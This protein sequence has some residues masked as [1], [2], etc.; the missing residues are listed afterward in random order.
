MTLVVASTIDG[1]NFVYSNPVTTNFNTG[2]AIEKVSGG[3]QLSNSSGISTD[4]LYN[5]CLLCFST[6][7]TADVTSMVKNYNQTNSILV[8]YFFQFPLVDTQAHADLMRYPLQLTIVGYP[9][10]SPGAIQDI[11]ADFVYVPTP[12]SISEP[13]I[14]NKL[15]ITLTD[16]SGADISGADISGAK[17][18]PEPVSWN[19]TNTKALYGVYMSNDSL[20]KSEDIT[21]DLRNLVSQI[22]TDKYQLPQAIGN[23]FAN[24]FLVSTQING[25]PY[26]SNYVII[27][28]GVY[29]GYYDPATDISG[30]KFYYSTNFTPV[31]IAIPEPGGLASTIKYNYVVYIC[32]DITMTPA[33]IV[34]RSKS[35]LNVGP[36]VKNVWAVGTDDPFITLESVTP[37]MP[38]D[39]KVVV[40]ASPDGANV[41][42][43]EPSQFNKLN[44]AP[45]NISYDKAN[46]SLTVP[47]SHEALQYPDPN[48][49][50]GTAPVYNVIYTVPVTGPIPPTIKFSG[51]EAWTYYDYLPVGAATYTF[52]KPLPTPCYLVVSY[53][54]D[55]N[56]ASETVVSTVLKF[57]SLTN[58]TSLAFRNR[59]YKYGRRPIK[60]KKRNKLYYAVS[61]AGGAP[62][63]IGPG[64]GL[65]VYGFNLG[66][67]NGAQYSL[68]F[69]NPISYYAA[70]L[71]KGTTLLTPNGYVNIEALKVGDLVISHRNRP[72][73]VLSVGVWRIE[74]TENIAASDLVYKVANGV[75]GAEKPLYI[76]AYHR[77]LYNGEMETA[78]AANLPLAK[79]EEVCEPD[80]FYTYYNVMVENHTMNNLVV[81]GGVVVESWDGKYPEEAK[82]APLILNPYATRV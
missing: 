49:P 61:A 72:V 7:L 20:I 11:A 12:I 80:G 6:D 70:C 4:P 30:G 1:M 52:T 40:S 65:S 56:A 2:I 63:Q 68:N 35:V 9:S 75:L 45:F 79:K 66:I 15:T 82:D 47:F 59:N 46:K 54:T 53:S 44:G 60:N 78:N 23:Q 67:S 24:K 55:G 18:K 31:P 48:L 41:H 62:P 37:G 34:A 69:P 39:I 58:V 21:A 29:G 25:K 26:Y 22:N 32:T 57:T 16:V 33:Q 5:K 71:L 73:K 51:I 8:P 42:F 28:T 50:A 19:F 74:W 64:D 36:G 38:Q 17:L 76:S 81:N 3:Y 10:V 14:N 13:D 77:I 27:D 43:S